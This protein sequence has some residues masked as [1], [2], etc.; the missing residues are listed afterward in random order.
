MDSFAP[1]RSIPS[2]QLKAKVLNQQQASELEYWLTL[3]GARE[4]N[5]QFLVEVSL[6]RTT[7]GVCVHASFCLLHACYG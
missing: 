3:N 2:L 6:P 1:H 7:Q 5:N 4:P